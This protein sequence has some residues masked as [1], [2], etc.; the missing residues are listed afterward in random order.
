M[1]GEAFLDSYSAEQAR[2]GARI[3]INL[4]DGLWFAGTPIVEI[5]FSM[6][7]LRAVE[8]GR[9][10]LRTDNLG[11]S[12]ILDG[13]GRVRAF[14]DYGKTGWVAGPLPLESGEPTPFLRWGDAFVGLCAAGLGLAALRRARS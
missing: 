8:T 13:R 4:S 11:P 7:V 3:L 14:L 1:C 6:N 5:A 12:A 9:P 2:R 10:L